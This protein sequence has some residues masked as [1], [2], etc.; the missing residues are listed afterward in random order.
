MHHSFNFHAS[1][2]C[3][4]QRRKQDPAY[5]I[6]NRMTV[7]FLEWFGHKLTIS[8]AATLFITDKFS[9][10]LEIFKPHITLQKKGTGYFFSWLPLHLLLDLSLDLKVDFNINLLLALICHTDFYNRHSRLTLL[11][12]LALYLLKAHA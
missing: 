9:W 4:F 10:H 8:V 5:R 3:A 2:C 11:R 6:S 7:P 12:P 1:N